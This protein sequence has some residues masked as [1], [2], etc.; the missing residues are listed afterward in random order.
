LLAALA[1]FDSAA[2]EFGRSASM[3]HDVRRLSVASLALACAALVGW[4]RPSSTTPATVYDGFEGKTLSKLWRTDKLAKGAV[5]MQSEQVRAG[6]SA[7]K[8][9]IHPGDPTPE[10]AAGGN[11]RDELQEDDDFN[12]KEGEAY[13]YEFSL[14]VPKDFPVVPKRLVLAQWKQHTGCA[15]VSVDNP[16][17]ALRYVD[18]ELSITIQSD[19]KKV[20]RYQTRREI[21]G[22]WLDFVFH[23]RHARTKNGFVRAWMNGDE[24][25]DFRGPTAYSENLRYPKTATFFFKMGLYRD[26]MSEPMTVFIDEY[27]KRPL[28]KKELP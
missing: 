24:I 17:I 7:A 12:A 13:A 20:P 21:K 26:G 19:G 6:Q 1:L 28:G 27:R 23:I 10:I 4:E 15:Q 5:V 25:L 8:L 22:R 9:T 2:A 14:F 3:R 16:V 18:G 11:E